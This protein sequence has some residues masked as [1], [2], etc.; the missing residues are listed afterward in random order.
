[1]QLIKRLVHAKNNRVWSVKDNF[2]IS[3]MTTIFLDL[4]KTLCNHLEETGFNLRP[5]INKE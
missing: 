5:V 3:L 2:R 1:M 4:K